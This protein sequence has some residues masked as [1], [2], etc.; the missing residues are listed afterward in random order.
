[1]SLREIV[2]DTETT[3]LSVAS[4][5]RV[6][7]IGAV[8][9]IDKVP[10]GRKFRSYLNPQRSISEGAYR[11]HGISAEFLQNKPLFIDVADELENFIGD[12]HLVIHNAPF[13]MSFLNNEFLLIGR[14]QIPFERAIDTLVIAK[15]LYPGFKAS[16]DALCKRF[17][18][19][20]SNR[21]FH[22]A[23]KDAELLA[24]VYM[25]MVGREQ[26]SLSMHENKGLISD[27][28]S[29]LATGSRIVITPSKNEAQAHAIL[30]ESIRNSLW[31]KLDRSNSNSC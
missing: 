21:S 23:L 9:L 27:K 28:T 20:L 10:T 1:M 11:V 17:K 22:G 8:E 30:I 18:I 12:S 3:G 14:K 25:E 19:D 26:T 6:I 13:D 16:L 4:G 29:V 24:L 15:K 2:L 5:H 31:Q 7:E